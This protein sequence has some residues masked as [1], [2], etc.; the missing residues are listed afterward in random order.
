MTNHLGVSGRFLQSELCS[1]V[2]DEVFLECVL[3]DDTYEKYE[4]IREDEGVCASLAFVEELFAD[5]GAELC[6]MNCDEVLPFGFA[7]DNFTGVED[8]FA[9][10]GCE[11]LCVVGEQG[12]T[13]GN[14]GYDG[15]NGGSGA[16]NDGETVIVV[17]AEV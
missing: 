6:D 14:D 12:I 3:E 15:G 13:G 11:S 4:E 17:V 1:G 9:E 8:F 5:C 16:E 2:D 10:N 7:Q